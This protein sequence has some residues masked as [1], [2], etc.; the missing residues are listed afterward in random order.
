[1]AWTKSSCGQG[2][3]RCM[4]VPGL[5]RKF[6]TITSCTWPWRAWLSAMASRARTRSIGS[7]PMPTRM[8]VVNGMAELAGGLE[9]GE[10]ARRRLVGRAAVALEVVAERLDHHPLRRARP[11]RRRA[12]S[13]GVQRAGVGVGEQAGLVE[14]EAAHGGEVVD[15]GAV[16]VVGEPLGGGRVALLG[17]LAEGEQRLV[18]AGLG[19]DAGRWRGPGRG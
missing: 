11:V 19:A 10:A 12:S 6:W 16:A 8:P 2:G 15:G 17:P 5:G 4:P 9:G 14:H 1:M 13:S 3:S 7:S 18:A